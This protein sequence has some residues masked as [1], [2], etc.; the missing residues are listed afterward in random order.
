MAMYNHTDNCILFVDNLNTS[1]LGNLSVR[2]SSI[3]YGWNQSK[4]WKQ[5]YP[6]VE[7]DLGAKKM[8]QIFIESK[9]LVYTYN[10]TGFLEAIASDKP[11]IIFFDKELFEIRDSAE[12]YFKLLKDAGIFHL[13]PMSAAK[14]V[15]EVWEN[16]NEWWQLE[17][18]RTALRIF[19]EKFCKRNN[20][21]NIINILKNS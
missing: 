19:G 18:T 17:N 16:V 10:S 20:I 8:K 11:F 1:L 6:N 7:I 4:I 3:D 13:N 21:K 2:L 9:L 12:P 14:H 5:K 15:N